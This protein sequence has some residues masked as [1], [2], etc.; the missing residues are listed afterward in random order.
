[1][2]QRS[3]SDSVDTTDSDFQALVGLDAQQARQTLLL[4][5]YPRY[6]AIEIYPEGTTMRMDKQF[7]RIRL[8]VDK[9]NKMTRIY[10][11]V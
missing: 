5:T 6:R 4:H 1:M 7:Y 3:M 2:I 9:H 11:M 8:M 10:N